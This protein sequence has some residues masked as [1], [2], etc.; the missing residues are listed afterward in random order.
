MSIDRSGDP[1]SGT[2]YKGFSGAAGDAAPSAA[3]RPRRS[4]SPRRGLLIAGVVAA[5][6]LGVVFGFLARPELG[7]A[8]AAS[9]G[10]PA[11]RTEPL[12]PPIAVKPPPPQPV[13][14]APGRLETLPPEMAQA[15]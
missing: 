7:P 12:G 6:A 8:P 2:T 5:L 14:T 1:W 4:M 3:A 10:A 11:A 13:P 9:N 15:A